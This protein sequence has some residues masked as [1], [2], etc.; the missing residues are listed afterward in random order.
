MFTG[1]DGN[2][3]KVRHAVGYVVF[4]AL[5]VLIAFLMAV[6]AGNIVLDF[7]ESD[8]EFYQY[9]EWTNINTLVYLIIGA[10]EGV[11]MLLCL[12]NCSILHPNA[13]NRK[14]RTFWILIFTAVNVVIGLAGAFVSTLVNTW[15]AESLVVHQLVFLLTEAVSI[16]LILFV[17]LVWGRNT[18]EW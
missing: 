11:M 10:L 18:F 5:A 12:V 8:V 7:V 17:V 14:N 9:N 16:C 13:R 3:T 15:I 4:F 2:Q 1:K 6:V